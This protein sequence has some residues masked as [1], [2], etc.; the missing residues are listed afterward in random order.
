MKPLKVVKYLVV[1]CVSNRCDRPFSV[2]SLI[3]CGKQKF[4]QVSYHYYVRYDGSVIPLLPESVQGVH[5]RHYNYCSLG[6]VYEGGLD[7][8]GV[9]ADTRTEA[10]KH[11][12]YELLKELTAEYPDA[13]IVGHC[14]LPHVAKKC[15][16]FPAS[17]EYSQLQPEGRESMIV[18]L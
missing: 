2:E 8:K 10:Q 18:K 11:S 9:A 12:L 16:C 13:R 6:I 15:P 7:E 3:N 1:H 17:T 4:G 5:A 14:E